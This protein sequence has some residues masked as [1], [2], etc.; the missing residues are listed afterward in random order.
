[1]DFTILNQRVS[2]PRL[3]HAFSAHGLTGNL[4]WAL[5]PVFFRRASA[6]LAE[7]ACRL[8]QRR[9]DVRAGSG[10][11]VDASEDK[12][13]TETVAARHADATHRG[14][15]GVHEAAGGVVVLSVFSCCPP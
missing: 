7:L 14:R 5:A 10:G 12:L 4:G 6:R 13:R 8:F 1:V 11:A 15:H 3:G 9:G 2:T